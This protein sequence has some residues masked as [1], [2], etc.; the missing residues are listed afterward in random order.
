MHS[1]I[2]TCTAGFAIKKGKKM[3]SV[4]PQSI[5]VGL[6]S[7]LLQLGLKC[8]E[9]REDAVATGQQRRALSGFYPTNLKLLGAAGLAAG[10][11]P[12]GAAP[13]GL[14]CHS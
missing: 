9:L 11:N 14:T 5:G 7:E 12:T 2:C 10:C 3:L 1:W 4:C 13:G 8:S 6:S